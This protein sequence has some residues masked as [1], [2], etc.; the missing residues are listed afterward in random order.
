MHTEETMDNPSK[1]LQKK[2]L[3][4]K[5]QFER[6]KKIRALEKKIE[7]AEEEIDSQSYH[8]A[9][10]LYG[11]KEYQETAASLKKLKLILAD[12]LKEWEELH[13]I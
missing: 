11:T 10:L 6:T 13:D 5:E 12:L 1:N 2:S 7:E 9:E 4:T 8:F 3:S